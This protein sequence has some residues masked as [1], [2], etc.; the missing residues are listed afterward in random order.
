MTTNSGES[1]WSEGTEI[2]YYD[3]AYSWGSAAYN[4]LTQDYQTINFDLSQKD[5]W[6]NRIITGLRFDLLTAIDDIGPMEIHTDIDY[7]K[8]SA[9]TG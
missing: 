5:D 6:N 8:I 2:R 3:Q 4:T 9:N 7:I 1:E